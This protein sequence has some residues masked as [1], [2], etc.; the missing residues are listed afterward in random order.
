MASEPEWISFRRRLRLCYKDLFDNVFVL[1]PGNSGNS[2][3]VSAVDT[4]VDGFA[5]ALKPIQEG[6]PEFN[7]IATQDWMHSKSLLYH[8]KSMQERPDYGGYL[9]DL[10]REIEEDYTRGLEIVQEAC[11]GAWFRIVLIDDC[12]A[13]YVWQEREEKED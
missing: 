1:S 3:D 13:P 12:F 11:N 6:R 9:R 7:V 2:L 5:K 8:L 4:L 10:R